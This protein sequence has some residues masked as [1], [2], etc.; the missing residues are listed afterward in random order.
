MFENAFLSLRKNIG[1]TILL[2]II[3]F[4]IA[5]LVIAGFSIR[6]V[7]AKTMNSIKDTLGNEVTLTVNFQNM[8]KQRDEQDNEQITLTTDIADKLK[9]L[10]YVENYNYTVSA[11]VNSDLSAVSTDTQ[12]SQQLDDRKQMPNTS[13]FSI[14]ANTTME[15]LSEFNNDNYSLLSGRVLKAD[16]AGS[17]NCVIETNLAN[18]ND[19]DVGD[20]LTISSLEDESMTVELIVVG[21]FEISNTDS[22]VRMMN[23]NPVNT[24]YTDLSVGQLINND[25]NVLSSA[26]YYLDDS[27]NVEAF[28]TLAE[29]QT[30]LD[31]EVYS[32]N[33]NNQMFEKN[34][35][36]INNMDSFT[37]IFLIVVIG[38]GCAILCL[39]LALTIRNRY[40]EIGIFLSLG[41]SKIR[42]IGQQLIEI[43]IIAALAFTISLGTG[44]MTS[45]IISGMLTPSQDTVSDAGGFRENADS[46]PKQRGGLDFGDAWQKTENEEM[47]VSMTGD[48]VIKL[49]ITTGCICI[50]STIIPT[51]YVL[52]LSPRE[53]LSRKAG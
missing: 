35:S 53:I 29:D 22:D 18:E 47:D 25:E 21:I 2:L 36:S 23:M 1:K 16:D 24:I 31:W 20:T 11:N 4:I 52:R 44:K 46:M 51:I 38:A 7:S 9:D 33:D 28:M 39:I 5:N 50:V 49:L 37:K 6:N 27:E 17:T 45:N 41:Q 15:Y 48:T 32:L 3:M 13:D 30:D 26:V 42:I 10:K 43:G 19:L 14:Q 34:A 40:Y 8:M 12:Q